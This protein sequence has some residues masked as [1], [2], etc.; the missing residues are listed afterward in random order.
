MSSIWRT[1]MPIIKTNIPMP[2]KRKTQPARNKVKKTKALVWP[3]HHLI[4]RPR[5]ASK[6]STRQRRANIKI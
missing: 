2:S 4:T 6:K 5:A 1:P 3:K